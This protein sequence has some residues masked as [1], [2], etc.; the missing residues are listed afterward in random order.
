METSPLKPGG[1]PVSS[2]YT[3]IAIQSKSIYSYRRESG[4]G[5]KLRHNPQLLELIHVISAQQLRQRGAVGGATWEEKGAAESQKDILWPFLSNYEHDLLSSFKSWLCGS[6]SLWGSLLQSKTLPQRGSSGYLFIARKPL[7]EC[8]PAQNAHLCP[9][10]QSGV[11]AV[12]LPS[13]PLLR[14][15]PAD[16]C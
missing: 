7:Q 12:P 4:G 15:G 5:A 6:L 3:N 2:W 10:Q 11:Q 9:Q 14:R 1:P 16:I 8:H 13:Q